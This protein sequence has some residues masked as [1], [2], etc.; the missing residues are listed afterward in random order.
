M[1]GLDRSLN[2]DRITT[3]LNTS[4]FVPAALVRISFVHQ[5]GI[6]LQR[7]ARKQWLYHAWLG[8]CPWCACTRWCLQHQLVSEAEG[9]VSVPPVRQLPRLQLECQWEEQ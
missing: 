2:S 1:H 5:V 6:I 3:Q 7:G 4:F 9:V 8:C